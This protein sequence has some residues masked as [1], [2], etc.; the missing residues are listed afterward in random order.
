M[1]W[2]QYPRFHKGLAMGSMTSVPD[3]D[4]RLLVPFRFGVA[5]RRPLN[6]W[7]PHF[8]MG[9]IKLKNSAIS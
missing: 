2:W 9:F 1:R 6:S 5:G 7:P 3:R 8:R 4:K